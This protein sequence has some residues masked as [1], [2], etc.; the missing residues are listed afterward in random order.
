MTSF[1][2][3]GGTRKKKVC[4][5]SYATGCHGICTCVASDINTLLGTH[6]IWRF[7]DLCDRNFGELKLVYW[8]KKTQ[9]QDCHMEG[10]K[11]NSELSAD[12]ATARRDIRRRNR[13]EDSNRKS[14]S[15]TCRHHAKT[16]V[17]RSDTSVN[18]KF[19]NGWTL[20]DKLV[21]KISSS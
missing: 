12:E 4:V 9:R 13:W 2:S 15:S 14:A 8:L 20:V 1:L 5:T 11:V 10:A 19:L 6:P 17:V 16:E 3:T 7:T 21:M 18:N